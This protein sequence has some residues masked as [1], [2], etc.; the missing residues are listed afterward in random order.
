MLRPTAFPILSLLLPITLSITL[1][2]AQKSC[3]G[4][5]T[6]S[7][8]FTYTWTAANETDAAQYPPNAHFSP[9]VCAASSKATLFVLGAAASPGF[10]LIAETGE[11]GIL[12]EELG[13]S[14]GESKEAPGPPVGTSVLT[15]EALD[16]KLDDKRSW[17]GCASMIAPSPDWVVGIT[18]RDMCDRETGKWKTGAQELLG[19]YTAG[20][21][22]GTSYLA[23][24]EATSGLIEKTDVGVIANYGYW[25]LEMDA[26][27][28]TKEDEKD[29]EDDD[30]DGVCFP[31]G[32]AVELESGEVKAV[33]KIA[34]GDRVHVGRGQFSEV[35]M[36]THKVADVLSAF[37]EVCAESGA[38]LRLSPGH[39]LFV[40]GD[41]VAA[42]VVQVGDIVTLGDGRED[43]VLSVA[44]VQRKGLYNPQTFDGRIVVD[45]ILAST[46]TT[47]VE[48]A[49][50][51]ALLA[52]MRAVYALFG[53]T[54]S[55]LERGNPFNA[56]PGLVLW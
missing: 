53:V 18:D 28:D 14:A 45:G 54:S 49:L 25:Q 38:V 56:S 19:P 22:A 12:T 37:V 46:F 48:P 23:A 31:E 35:F 44:R 24:N 4:S 50:A 8:T 7:V 9:V 33:E 32:A 42:R 52:P 29:G 6:L 1:A 5:P 36:W 2:A 51:H 41:L 16:F 43:E 10:K 39:F 26:G 34:I 21:D 11:T 20:T 30:D 13:R 15:T 47:A 55:A 3:T 17:I 40:N 27:D